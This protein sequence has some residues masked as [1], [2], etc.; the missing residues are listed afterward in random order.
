MSKNLRHRIFNYFLLPVISIVVFFLLA[1]AVL[2]IFGV[3]P[4]PRGVEFT[5]NRAPDHPD[6]FYRDHNLFWRFR[7]DRTIVSKFFEGKS[8]R[9][10][11]QGFR[12][13]DFDRDHSGPLVAVLGNSCSFG[14]GVSEKESFAGRLETMLRNRNDTRNARVYNFSVPGY[15]S[16]QGKINYREKVRP[17]RP[18]ILL[19]TFAWNDQWP[20][21]EKVPDKA[22]K[23]PPQWILDI[24]NLIGRTRLYRAVKSVIFSLSG[25]REQAEYR[26]QA[27]RVEL[28]DFRHNIDDIIEMGRND[29][30]RVILL[31]SPAPDLKTYYNISA[32]SYLHERHRHYNEIIR[33]AA[34]AHSAPLVDL[35]GLFDHYDNLFDDVARDP[36]HYNRRGHRLAAEAILEVLIEYL[37]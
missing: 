6:V 8:Y 34:A 11:R 1:E 7:P 16:Y 20:A 17:F 4:Y 21:A 36:F 22:Q 19:V 32:R 12:G 23:M 13:E 33:E 5:V 9:I 30:A 10:N 27:P 24:H 18:D 35:A 2:H 25:P 37:E 26:D 28:G 31:T 3:N 15:S 14:W 29:G